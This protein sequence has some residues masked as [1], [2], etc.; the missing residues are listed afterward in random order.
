[1][2]FFPFASQVHVI[3]TGSRVLHLEPRE[4]GQ[5][6]SAMRPYHG[7]LLLQPLEELLSTLPIDASPALVRLAK[8]VNPLKNLQ[9]L[10]LDSDLSL[11]QVDC[12][13]PA[14]VWV[15]EGVLLVGGVAAESLRLLGWLRGRRCL[16]V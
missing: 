6:L 4:V 1:M 10:S 9:T 5:C 8:M 3:V 16:V 11:S 15:V 7:L 12:R 13:I 14:D 2:F